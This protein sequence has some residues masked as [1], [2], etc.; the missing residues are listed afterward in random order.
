MR[1]IDQQL[2]CIGCMLALFGLVLYVHRHQARYNCFKTTMMHQ[3]QFLQNQ[4][5]TQIP[6][7]YLFY[8]SQ[9]VHHSTIN[10]L[11]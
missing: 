10:N 6:P 5:E 2:M 9:S 7:L 4:R 11:V 1:P 3:R 8:P